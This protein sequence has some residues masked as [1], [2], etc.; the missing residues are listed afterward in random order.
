[1]K[2]NYPLSATCYGMTLTVTFDWYG[3]EINRTLTPEDPEMSPDLLDEL[4]ARIYE[5]WNDTFTTT[6]NDQ[7][8]PIEVYE[9]LIN[10]LTDEELEAFDMLCSR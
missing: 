9:A 4:E 6:H 1:M 5:Q 3:A 8:F 10:K 7:L 2:R